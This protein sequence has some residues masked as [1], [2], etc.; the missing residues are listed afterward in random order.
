YIP[1]APQKVG[2]FGVTAKDIG[3]WYGGFETRYF[4]PRSLIEDDSV[5]SES[6]ILAYGRIGNK[7]SERT[8]LTLDGFNLF[9]RQASDID[10]Y[11]Q[12]RLPGEGQTAPTTSISIP[13]S[14]ALRA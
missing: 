2:S 5:R 1:E 11:Y 3:R 14:R 12:S 4:G 7:F 10:D 8:S 13:P 6:T 9:N